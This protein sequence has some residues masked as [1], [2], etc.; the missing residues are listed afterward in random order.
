MQTSDYESIPLGETRRRKVYSIGLTITSDVI[1]WTG[2]WFKFVEIE[3][4]KHKVRYRYFDDGWTYQHYWGNWKE[5]WNFK[6]L[7]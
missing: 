5:E 4:E 2:K 7:I 3:E 1:V 6:K